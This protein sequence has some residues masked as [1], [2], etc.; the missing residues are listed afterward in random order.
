MGHKG[1]V[2][3]SLVASG[4]WGLEPNLNQLP[5]KALYWRKDKR[6][7]I[8]NG[9]RWRRRKQLLDDIKETRRCWK[10]KQKALD[11]TLRRTRFLKRL[12]TWQW[13]CCWRHYGMYAWMNKW[14][15]CLHIWSILPYVQWPRVRKYCC[16]LSVAKSNEINRIRT[17]NESFLQQTSK[18]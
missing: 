14:T 3:S 10:L 15:T 9:L 5:C 2:I 13:T 11:C 6:K 18:G 12:R 1:P 17:G 4:P 16:Q 7:N 8:S